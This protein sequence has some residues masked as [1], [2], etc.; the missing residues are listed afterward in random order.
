VKSFFDIL[1]RLGLDHELC[2]VQTLRQTDRQTD[3]SCS[4]IDARYIEQ[5]S[6]A[7]KVYYENKLQK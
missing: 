6:N 7:V 2:D 3:F 1:N 5:R 4:N